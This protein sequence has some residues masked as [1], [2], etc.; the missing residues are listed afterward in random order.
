MVRFRYDFICSQISAAVMGIE[1]SYAAETAFV[2][3]TLL[4]IGVGII[5]IFVIVNM[6]MVMMVMIAHGH[7]GELTNMITVTR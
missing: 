5:I 1:F 4:E 6:V 7:E 2:S 3:P